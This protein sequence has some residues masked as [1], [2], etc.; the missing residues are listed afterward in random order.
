MS[1]AKQVRL[2]FQQFSLESSSSCKYDWAMLYNGEFAFE[3]QRIETVRAFLMYKCYC[4]KIGI[5]DD[6]DIYLCL[7]LNTECTRFI[8]GI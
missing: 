5:V 4:I 3:A 8:L 7:V 6:S 1:Y 2:N